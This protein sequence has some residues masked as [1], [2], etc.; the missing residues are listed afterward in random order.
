MMCFYF[1]L[2]ILVYHQVMETYRLQK[3]SQI[4]VAM[5]Q[6]STKRLFHDCD[7]DGS[8]TISRK[9]LEEHFEKNGLCPDLLTAAYDDID[10]EDGTKDD[11]VSI[12]EL[13]KGFRKHMRAIHQQ[14]HAR[15]TW[16]RMKV[17]LG[18]K[19]KGVLS[20]EAELD[21]GLVTTQDWSCGELGFDPYADA[22]DNGGGIYGDWDDDPAVENPYTIKKFKEL[23]KFMVK[24]GYDAE[25]LNRCSDKTAMLHLYATQKAGGDQRS[26][27]ERDSIRNSQDETTHG[28]GGGGGLF[29]R[30]ANKKEKAN[31]TNKTTTV[32]TDNIGVEVQMQ[33]ANQ[34]ANEND[35]AVN[36]GMV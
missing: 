34:T 31:K 3:R 13:M 27:T 12:D 29:S 8:G 30:R 15:K 22:F 19:L 4:A 35:D 25:T 1:A 6:G 28:D 18:R 36:S 16:A 21:H 11:E 9:E 33:S 32:H 26:E 14:K 10:M 17:K 20:P 23:K 7:K 5:E 24:R 2:I